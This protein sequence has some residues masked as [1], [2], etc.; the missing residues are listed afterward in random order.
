MSGN[1]RAQP[2]GNPGE[3]VGPEGT[4]FHENNDF[5]LE[6]VVRTGGVIP[7]TVNMSPSD[8]GVVLGA[9]AVLGVRVPEATR[10]FGGRQER[11]E[12]GLTGKLSGDTHRGQIRLPKAD[13]VARNLELGETASGLIV[14]AH[15]IETHRPK[16][17]AAPI[18]NL[19]KRAVG[20]LADIR[21]PYKDQ[22][23]LREVVN[24]IVVR[25]YGRSQNYGLSLNG[26]PGPGHSIPSPL[27]WARAVELTGE[28]GSQS[29][30]LH[31]GVQNGFE[32]SFVDHRQYKE[33]YPP[34]LKGLYDDIQHARLAAQINNYDLAS[35]IAKRMRDDEN[36]PNL[37]Q[38]AHAEG[39]VLT[40]EN[41]QQV[42]DQLHADITHMRRVLGLMNKDGMTVDQAVARLGEPLRSIPDSVRIHMTEEH[43]KRRDDKRESLE[44]VRQMRQ[45]AKIQ[46]KELKE[47]RAAVE[48]TSAATYGRA[49]VADPAWNAERARQALNDGDVDIATTHAMAL[50]EQQEIGLS[51]AGTEFGRLWAEAA[52]QLLMGVLG[53]EEDVRNGVISV[54]EMRLI[55]RI[56]PNTLQGDP[57][58]EAIIRLKD[59]LN[60]R[61]FGFYGLGTIYAPKDP[62]EPMDLSGDS[63]ENAVAE[64]FG[65]IHRTED[66]QAVRAG[67]E[68][69]RLTAARP[70]LR[71]PQ[72]AELYEVMRHRWATT[73]LNA[74]EGCDPRALP[75]RLA[76]QLE[77]IGSWAREL[78]TR[79][80]MERIKGFW[81]L[82][83][84]PYVDEWR[85]YLKT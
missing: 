47:R 46:R 45:A 42:L 23:R 82:V 57:V 70:N 19:G 69:E 26:E 29:A 33:G 14:A 84:D 34:E 18:R 38:A 60:E 25:N 24:D 58:R 55:A 83:A 13:D 56:D 76:V 65:G 50:A 62:G 54:G 4:I 41:Y 36:R 40:R 30:I 68:Y 79:K 11:K 20:G 1:E 7:N 85:N 73:L 77:E 15:I 71:N 10:R 48:T 22:L 6:N 44:R 52:P 78:G 5:V 32:N 16:P 31:A 9:A 28:R 3:W 63:P 59:A 53:R 43:K 74:A 39:V 35:R 8:R 17:I 37:A 49:M 64:K 66:Q 12:A 21:D 81:H 67:Y 27:L 80:R 72:Q 61:A 51:G 75:Q 2:G